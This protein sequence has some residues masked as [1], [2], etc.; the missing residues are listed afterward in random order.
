MT[1]GDLG[2]RLPP[3]TALLLIDVQQAIDDPKWMAEGPRNNPQAES[4][5]AALL[6]AWRQGFALPPW[7]TGK[8][9]Q[10]GGPTGSRRADHCETDEQRFRRHR[11]GGDAACL[12]YAAAGASALRVMSTFYCPGT[13]AEALVDELAAVCFVERP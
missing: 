10:A 13:R 3:N 5:L 8:R 6:A 9:V 4:N 11:I 2:L 7:S 1:A 12:I